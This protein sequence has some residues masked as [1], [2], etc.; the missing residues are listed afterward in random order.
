MR[1]CVALDRAPLRSYASRMRIERILVPVDYSSCS[2]ASLEYAV[3]LADLL[4]ATI[5]VV[6]V[7]DRPSYV[8]DVT[9]VSQPS[10]L[11][12]PLG[13]LI[14]ENAQ[15]DMNEFLKGLQGPKQAPI[16]GRLLSGEPAASLLQE[17]K[18]GRYDL[19][20]LGT[21]GRT[22]LTHL[23]LGSVAEKLTRHSPVPVLTIPDPE[24]KRSS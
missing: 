14:R 12:R 1:R 6:H 13:E 10:G 16:A 23:L 8:S 7:W 5:D 11:G 22:G 19:V 9:V 2:R 20:V 3:E 24:K 15:L 21:H 18:T 4:G 17:L